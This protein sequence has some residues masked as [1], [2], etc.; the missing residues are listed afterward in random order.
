MERA[1]TP[2]MGSSEEAAI[3]GEGLSDISEPEVQFV[4]SR[5]PSPR[6]LLPD[7]FSVGPDGEAAVLTSLP[8]EA[9]PVPLSS[10][11]PIPNQENIFHGSE[12]VNASDDFAGPPPKCVLSYK[13]RSIQLW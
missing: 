2:L 3:L 11:T 10:S 7:P 12:N 9:A 4:C 1:A 6:P 8:Q 13:F 5:S